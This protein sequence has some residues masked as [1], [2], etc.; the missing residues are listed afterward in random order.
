M[1]VKRVKFKRIHF[2]IVYLVFALVPNQPDSVKGIR[3]RFQFTASNSREVFTF[4]LFCHFQV[5]L[6]DYTSSWSDWLWFYVNTH[7]CFM[8]SG[9]LERPFFLSDSVCVCVLVLRVGLNNSLRALEC[10]DSTQHSG[11][12]ESRVSEF[13]CTSKRW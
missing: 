4:T 5:C 12:S 6:S 13:T 2:M 7:K 1:T 11:F 10:L 8:R 9:F 3:C